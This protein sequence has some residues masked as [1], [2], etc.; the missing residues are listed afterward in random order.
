MIVVARTFEISSVRAANEHK[1]APANWITVPDILPGRPK[2]P[3]KQRVFVPLVG[4][5]APL[6]LQSYVNA[7][8]TQGNS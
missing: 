7:I 1:Q 8:F 3:F 4:L 5:H 2:P 6:D